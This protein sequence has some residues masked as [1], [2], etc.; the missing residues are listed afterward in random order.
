MP[1]TRGREH[2]TFLVTQEEEDEGDEEAATLKRIPKLLT[3][4]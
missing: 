2:T 4:V 1:I 3:R